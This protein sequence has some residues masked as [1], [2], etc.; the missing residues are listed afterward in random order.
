MFSASKSY[1][2]TM[3]STVISSSLLND[4]SPS[5]K[6]PWSSF[7][8]AAGLTSTR[9]ASK[10]LTTRA[11][12]R[13]L[14]AAVVVLNLRRKKSPPEDPMTAKLAASRPVHPEFAKYSIF[15]PLRSFSTAVERK[16][17]TPS[18]SRSDESNASTPPDGRAILRPPYT[19]PDMLYMQQIDT[20][21]VGQW[22]VTN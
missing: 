20:P 14:A 6:S 5:V 18:S 16:N 7:P 3:A 19:L 17:R 9:K 8:E 10:G 4:V 12:R 2:K 11:R 15:T 22:D 1:V 13:T 21:R